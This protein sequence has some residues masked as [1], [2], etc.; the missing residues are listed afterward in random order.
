MM[1]REK[2]DLVIFFVLEIFAIVWAGTMFS[3][4]S[5]RLLA[6]GLAGGYF[7]VSGLFMLWRIRY[8]SHPWQ[9]LTTYLL[10]VHVFLISF[11][12]LITRW[13]HSSEDF[14]DVRIFGLSGPEF[15]RL[16]TAVFTILILATIVDWIR[17]WR[18][19]RIQNST[20]A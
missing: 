10:I 9:A 19:A 18:V 11:P 5:S 8:W 20:S 17:Q 6:G 1:G 12:M 7:V 2:R 4:L 13:M 14:G 16:S 15:H 3:L